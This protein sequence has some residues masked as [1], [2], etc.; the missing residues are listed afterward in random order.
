MDPTTVGRILFSC[1][2]ILIIGAAFI[3][4]RRQKRSPPA[5]SPDASPAQ[6]A[7]MPAT[8]LTRA[9]NIAT[10]GAITVIGGAIKARNYHDSLPVLLLIGAG[11]FVFF[12]IAGYLILLLIP[13][14]PHKVEP[15]K[16]Y[17]TTTVIPKIDED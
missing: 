6:V 14:I 12:G 2:I 5:S 16:P 10:L 17:S 4:D 11:G 13:S 1:I 7:A 15:P 8:K 9:R 3:N